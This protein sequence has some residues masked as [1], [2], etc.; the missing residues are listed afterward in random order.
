MRTRSVALVVPLLH[1]EHETPLHPS[2]LLPVLAFG[3]EIHKQFPSPSQSDSYFFPVQ[4]RHVVVAALRTV[5]HPASAV[6]VDPAVD[7]V[8]VRQRPVALPLE[9]AFL[10]FV[11]R[12]G[13]GHSSP[14]FLAS[15]V[16]LQSGPPP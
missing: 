3:Y 12:V 13:D 1:P 9:P 11:F 4:P 7:A 15:M 2:E 14:M 8:L 6:P 5:R 16:F 10:A